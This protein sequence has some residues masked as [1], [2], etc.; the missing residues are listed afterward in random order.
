MS[1]RDQNADMMRCLSFLFR[2]VRIGRV[3]HLVREVKLLGSWTFDG[4]RVPCI[5]SLAR[6]ISLDVALNHELATVVDGLNSSAFRRAS[7]VFPH[8]VIGS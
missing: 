2:N 5:S 4:S 8:H 6:T 7:F 3:D 1:Y